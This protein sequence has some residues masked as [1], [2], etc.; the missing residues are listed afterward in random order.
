ML[1][2][3]VI[4]GF[5][6]PQSFFAFLQ[7]SYVLGMRLII[8]KASHVWQGSYRSEYGGSRNSVR[9]EGRRRPL[10]SVFFFFFFFFFWFGF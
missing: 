8:V 2:G 7:S 5:L 3:G 6:V 4:I 9:R 1:I 10:S